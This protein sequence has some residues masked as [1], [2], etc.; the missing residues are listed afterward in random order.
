MSD[1]NIAIHPDLGPDPWLRLAPRQGRDGKTESARACAAFEQYYRSSPRERSLRAVA[2]KVGKHRTLISQWSSRF[3][4]V[5]RTEAWDR[6]QNEVAA[7]QYERQLREEEEVWN[8]RKKALRE[9]KY[10][11]G[12]QL[13][14]RGAFMVRQPIAEKTMQRP[15]ASGNQIITLK[16]N[17]RLQQTGVGMILAGFELADQSVG[18]AG[19]VSVAGQLVDVC[20]TVPYDSAEDVK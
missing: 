13:R 20:Q 7:A 11:V 19:P 18:Q 10:A 4:W 15:D 17:P 12:Q 9:E 5:E 1:H 3:R 14:E 16:P 6:R 8:K 2:T